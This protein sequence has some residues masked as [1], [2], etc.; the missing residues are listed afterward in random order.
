MK[1]SNSLMFKSNQVSLKN[2][3]KH[4]FCKTLS[5]DKNQLSNSRKVSKNDGYLSD[6]GRDTKLNK[7]KTNKVQQHY[8]KSTLQLK[9][10]KKQ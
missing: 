8:K 9:K 3:F 10:K 5:R 1:H 4:S 2:A 6:R 7:H